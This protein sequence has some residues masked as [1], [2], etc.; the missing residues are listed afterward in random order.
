MRAGRAG[1]RTANE[2]TAM[3][4][5][6]LVKGD[7]RSEAGVV[8]DEQE[9]AEMGK[10]NEQLVKSGVMLA[11]EGLQATAKGARIRYAGGTPTVVEGPFAEAGEIVAGFW[12]LQVR[13]REEAIEW[14][15]RAPFKDG[16]LEIRQVFEAADLSPARR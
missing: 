6:V 7:E 16:E 9:L 5:I 13:S 14:M 4:F 10:F 8:P 15:K 12:M 11:G 3:R 1:L 2:E